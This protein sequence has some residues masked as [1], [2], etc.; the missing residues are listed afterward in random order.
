M[1]YF[2][3]WGLLGWL[4]TPILAGMS[5]IFMV[6][7][8]GGWAQQMPGFSLAVING[9]AVGEATRVAR[10]RAMGLAFAMHV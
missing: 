6:Q 7:H 1:G 10:T 5:V 3:A 9:W 4:S 2:V 8:S